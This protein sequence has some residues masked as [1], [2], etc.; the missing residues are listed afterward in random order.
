MGFRSQHKSL[1]DLDRQLIALSS[2]LCFVWPVYCKTSDSRLDL[3][4]SSPGHDTAWLF[5]TS[6]AAKLSCGLTIT[7][8]NS[9]LYPSGVAKSSTS[10][11]WGKRG[12]VTT[13]GWQVTLCDPYGV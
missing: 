6:L 10:F 2:E 3:S 12:K 4:G 1:N 9:A 11:G 7:L 8:V 13:A 5:L